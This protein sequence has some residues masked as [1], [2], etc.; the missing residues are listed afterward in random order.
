MI[1]ILTLDGNSEKKIRFVTA[2]DLPNALNISNIRDLSF[3]QHFKCHDKLI[4]RIFKSLI[5]NM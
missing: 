1:M 4:F 2:L 5:L 3:L